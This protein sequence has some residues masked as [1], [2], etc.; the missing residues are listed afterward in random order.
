MG[1][2]PLK[3]DGMQ[4]IRSTFFGLLAGLFL[5]L[6]WLTSHAVAQTAGDNPEVPRFIFP[7][8]CEIG[9]DC[10]FVAYMD[11]DPSED[12]RDHMCGLRTYD[13]HKGTDIAPIDP[14]APVAVI[15][16]ADGMVLG[17]RD[18]MDDSL[19]RVRDE[20]RMAAQCGNGVRLDHG[21]GWTS[22]YCHLERGS[23]TVRTGAR[24]TAGQ[25]LGWIGSSGRSDFR[26]LHFQVE[27]DGTQ[28][29][30]FDGAVPSEAPQCEVASAV[31][32]PLWQA[33]DARAIA[34]YTPLVI[35]QAGIATRAPDR[36]GMLYDG[37]PDTASINADALVGYVVLLGVAAGTT[38]DTIITGPDG[39]RF[40]ENR[41]ILDEDRARSFVSIGPRRKTRE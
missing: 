19:M 22:Q 41:R 18:G 36:E 4:A 26:H 16:A 25:I 10:W 15:A 3:A 21:N 7:A 20:T 13:A 11:H 2:N 8:G 30:P 14:A 23:V 29:D 40:F 33:A 1:V 38:V 27:R 34:D 39:K 32:R 28:V 35:Y 17:A 6:P 31:D 5:T 9:Q 37:Y 24:V 12:Y